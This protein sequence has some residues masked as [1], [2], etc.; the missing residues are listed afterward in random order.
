MT[1]QPW[2]FISY[3]EAC[4]C[5]DKFRRCRYGHTSLWKEHSAH[6]LARLRTYGEK[7]DFIERY[8]FS[9]LLEDADQFCHWDTELDEYSA[10]PPEQVAPY[11]ECDLV[12]WQAKAVDFMKRLLVVDWELL[13]RRINLM[14]LPLS[15]QDLKES[16]DWWSVLDFW[17]GMLFVPLSSGLPL[18][19]DDEDENYVPTITVVAPS[20]ESTRTPSRHGT[21]PLED[22]PCP[23]PS[24]PY[25]NPESDTSASPVVY[26]PRRIFSPAHPNQLLF[27]SPLM[28]QDALPS[29]PLDPRRPLPPSPGHMRPFRSFGAPTIGMA[30]DD[31]SAKP[32]VLPALTATPSLPSDVMPN[33]SKRKRQSDNTGSSLPAICANIAK[34][35]RC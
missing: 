23:T 31:P 26:A 29:F 17:T 32:I 6:L 10:H 33:I 35:R 11:T 34:R 27:P 8:Y 25:L 22:E 24:A 7:R 16:A 28:N 21:E 15:P 13:E 2:R 18:Y 1:G 9:I 5:F 19:N 12:S 4:E 14:K 30:Q 3:D 20:M